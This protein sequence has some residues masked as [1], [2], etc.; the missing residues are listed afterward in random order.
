MRIIEAF[1]KP[2]HFKEISDS[3][4]KRKFLTVEIRISRKVKIRM[5]T[6]HI[7]K[8]LRKIKHC[9]V[10]RDSPQNEEKEIQSQDVRNM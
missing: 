5:S 1:K 10:Y 2:P 3:Q 8:K 4:P 6:F 7:N 9:S